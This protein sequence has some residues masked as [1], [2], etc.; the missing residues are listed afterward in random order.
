MTRLNGYYLPARSTYRGMLKFIPYLSAISANNLGEAEDMGNGLYEI[1]NNGGIPGGSAALFGVK[2]YPDGN[3][4]IETPS[5]DMIHDRI[6]LVKLCLLTVYVLSAVAAVYLMRI[7]HKL[8]MHGKQTA[9]YGSSVMTAGQIARLV[10][11]LALLGTYAVYAN[12]Q[13]GIPVT[14]G[15]VIGI[16]QIICTA[17]CGISAVTSCI[18]FLS[19]KNEK[20]LTVRY[21]LN[22]VGCILPILAILYFEMYRFWGC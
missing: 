2:T 17:V 6:Y 9:F 8:K 22:T 21:I 10:S 1:R 20:V 11:V 15:A 18:S 16:V 3:S 12:C 19:H 14:A 13:G 4:G 5:M 7:R